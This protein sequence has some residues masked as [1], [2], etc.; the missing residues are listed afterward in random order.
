MAYYIQTKDHPAEQGS[1]YN[2]WTWGTDL[3]CRSY[4]KWKG[5]GWASLG[6]GRLLRLFPVM[7]PRFILSSAVALKCVLVFFL[8]F[9]SVYRMGQWSFLNY[10][11][12]PPDSSISPRPKKTWQGVSNPGW[13][14]SGCVHEGV[15]CW[16][17]ECQE[18]F[19][20][21]FFLNCHFLSNDN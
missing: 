5:R 4:L 13:K 18:M 8:S 3:L 19:L 21:Y 7:I 20:F 1:P 16:L 10:P 12:P 15:Y 17:S 11:P 14:T 6:S 9:V 2:K